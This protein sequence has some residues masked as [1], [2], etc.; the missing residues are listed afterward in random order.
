V[1]K[2]DAWSHFQEPRLPNVHDGRVTIAIGE[3]VPVAL[4]VE[5]VVAISL[6][7]VLI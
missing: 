3:I 1:S 5:L 7:F 4:G 2:Q 6:C